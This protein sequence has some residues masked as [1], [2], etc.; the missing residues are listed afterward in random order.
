MQ[1]FLVRRL[2][3]LVFVLFGIS[4]ITFSISHIVPADPARVAAG[5]RAGP[6]Q[7]ETIRKKMGL[8]KPLYMQYVTYISGL[9]HGDLGYSI[10]SRRPVL[11][12]FAD[13]FP[14]TI[15]L[16]ITA[17]IFVIVLGIP[18]G[19]LSAVKANRWPD[20]VSQFFCV[21]GVA[22]PVFWSGMLFQL[23]FFKWLGWLPAGGRIDVALSAPDRITGLYILDSLLRGDWEVFFNGLHH[24]IL[25][26]FTLSLPSLALVARMVRS[27]MLDVMSLDYVR[28]ARSKGL[29][30]MS[31]IIKHAL[32]NALI[33]TTTVLGLQMGMILAGDFLVEIIFNWP[34]LGLYAL[35][36][37]MAMDYMAIMS[38]TLLI[39]VSYMVANLIVDIIYTILDPRIKY[40]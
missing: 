37:I 26:A 36:T 22:M 13:Y 38:V 29:A 3:L 20:K 14:A 8:D 34:G 40:S 9:L 28:T 33:P 25:P 15:E 39:A 10:Y 31:V 2:L 24:V 12:D 7:V 32:R 4:L 16:A 21:S 5:P 11:E 18:L 30:E 1:A 35:N 23:L 27:T 19:V 17:M 6:E